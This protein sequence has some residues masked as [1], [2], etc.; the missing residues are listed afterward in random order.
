MNLADG[1]L[2]NSFTGLE[3][4]TI[5]FLQ[6]N[7]NKPIYPIGPIIQS[8]DGSIVADPAG[9]L[10]WL[11]DQPIGSVV[12]VSFGSGGTLSSEQLT[13]L[14]LGLEASQKRFIWVVRSPNDASASASYFSVD[15]LPKGFIDRVKGR[16]LVVPS[17]APQMQVL[18]H[19]ATGGFVSHCGWN[20]TLESLV[21]GVPIIAW[22]LYAE[23]KMNAVLLQKDIKV[24]LRP[25]QREDGVIGRD[26]IAKVVKELMEGEEGAA[27]RRRMAELKAAAAEAVGDG[28]SST[29]SLEELVC[30]WKKMG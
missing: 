22:P 27:V 8:S 4:E 26:E 5:R 21:N 18:S 11:D 2:I 24:A 13:E 30:V 20:S 19:V 7:G 3:G 15:F 29:K 23:Q 10:K 6:E 17:W 12:L 14:A 9:C 28:G 25:K 1:F 16:G